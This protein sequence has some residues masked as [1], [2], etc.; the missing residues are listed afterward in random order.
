MRTIAL[1]ARKGG[2]GKTTCAIHM[3]VLAQASG[4]RVMFFDLDP[5]RSLAAWWQSR[6]A[7]PPTLVETDASRLTVL[8]RGAASGGYALAVV[9]PPPAVTFDTAQVAGA[10]DL[11]LI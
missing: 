9:D 1:L 8:L 5:Q 4:L 6:A 3:G 10:A 2:S 11:V 7:S